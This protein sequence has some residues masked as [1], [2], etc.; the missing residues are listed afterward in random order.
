[1]VV[2]L[3]GGF[4]GAALAA[5]A[6]GAALVRLRYGA[7]D[8][9]TVA[10]STGDHSLTYVRQAPP[11]FFGHQ[12]LQ[13]AATLLAPTAIA[14]LVYALLASGTVRDDLGGYPPVN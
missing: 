12:P 7:L 11:V 6:V 9:N 13:I 1:M 14:S 2:G 8:F 5:A 4:V 10:L 3:S